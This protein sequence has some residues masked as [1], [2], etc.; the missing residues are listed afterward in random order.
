MRFILVDRVT[1]L[2]VGEHAAGIK[3]VSLSESFLADHFD[4]YAVMPGVLIVEALAQLGGLLAECSDLAQ[5][6][7]R[8]EAH[9]VRRAILAQIDRA[10]FARVVRP[11]D[12]ISLRC[13]LDQSIEGAARVQGEATVD[14]ELAAKCALTFALREV[15]IASVH[16]QRR[17]LYVQ[18]TRELP[19]QVE[20][21]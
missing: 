14:G 11:G 15:P 12:K 20:L 21:P 9:R 18:W 4:G 13:T 7:P 1:E 16:T 3:C 5:R 19:V 17:A 6:D 8:P 10:K 2:V